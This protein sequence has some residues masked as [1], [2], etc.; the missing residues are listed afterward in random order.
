MRTRDKMKG[1]FLYTHNVNI[2]FLIKTN[3]VVRFINN[4]P[5]ISIVNLCFSDFHFYNFNILCL[6]N[7]SSLF[8]Y[9][10][11]TCQTR[12]LLPDVL[13]KQNVKIALR[14]FDYTNVAALT[15][16]QSKD[17][18]Q[19]NQTGDCFSMST[20]LGRAFVSMIEILYHLCR[21]IPGLNLH[22][23]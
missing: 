8:I 3:I 20:L 17:Y 16:H 15:I 14:I 2:Y 9:F 6:Y 11:G 19:S 23:H 12:V 7:I 4:F 21:M 18:I 1:I 10:F 13:D 5:E 22:L